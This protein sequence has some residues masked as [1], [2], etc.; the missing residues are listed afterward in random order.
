MEDVDKIGVEL[1]PS[2]RR[3][4]EWWANEADP[5]TRHRQCRA[6]LGAGWEVEEVNLSAEF[7][8]FRKLQHF[9]K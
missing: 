1:P 3:Y 5:K 7:V 8:V 4:P 6:W 2:A 9:Q